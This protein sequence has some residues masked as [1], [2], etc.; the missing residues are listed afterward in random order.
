MVTTENTKVLGCRGFRSTCIV[1]TEAKRFRFLAA[2]S[3][4]SLTPPPQTRE[5]IL[6]VLWLVYAVR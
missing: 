3:C 1:N 6:L 4:L 2:T 5:E